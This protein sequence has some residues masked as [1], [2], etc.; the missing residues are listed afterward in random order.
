VVSAVDIVTQF[1]TGLGQAALLAAAAPL[2]AG[3]IKTAKARLQNRRGPGIFQPYYDL[4]KF[5]RKDSVVSPTTSWLFV[6]A[7]VVYFAASAAAAG[8]APV[9]APFVSGTGGALAD[10]FMLLYLFA[11]GRFFLALASL[12]AGSAFGGMGGSREMFIAVLAEPA[13][14]LALLAVAL[15]VGGTGLAGM[16]AKAATASWDLAE[17]FAAGAFFLVLVAETGRIPVDNPDT[18]LELTMIHEGMIL[19]Y[20]GRPLGLIHWAV[21]I[22]QLVMIA[23]FATLFLPGAPVSWPATAQAAL[24]VVKVAVTALALAATET[25]TN[26]MRLFRVP[27]FMA[28]AG[29][30]ALLAL[31]AQ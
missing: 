15:P 4:V 25:A 18:H 12:D 14:L 27:A 21:A 24:L 9:L 3:L 23:L 26:K 7:P 6:A 28:V 5:L 17:M 16:A 13:I 1:L 29:V 30:L 8:L 11:L 19:E 31:V 2:T 20:S 22:K 10:M